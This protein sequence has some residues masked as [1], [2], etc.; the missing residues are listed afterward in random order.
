MQAHNDLAH[1][2]EAVPEEEKVRKFLNGITDPELKVLRAVVTS[3]P[4]F[5]QDFTQCSEF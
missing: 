1:I 3:N 4:V 5:R 2:E